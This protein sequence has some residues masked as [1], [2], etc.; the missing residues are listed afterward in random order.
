MDIH[1]LE[2]NSTRLAV[3]AEKVQAVEV[4]WVAHGQE[5]AVLAPFISQRFFRHGFHS[6]SLASW[7]PVSERPPLPVMKE[8]WAHMDALPLFADYPFT[9]SGVSA[10][11]GPDRQILLLGALGLDARLA[12][13]SWGLSGE[14]LDSPLERAP[15]E[16]FIAL[17]PEADVFERYARLLGERL[18]RRAR[19][20]APRVWC[21]WYSLFRDIDEQTLAGILSGV[22]GMR[23]DVFQVDDGW[24]QTLGDWEANDRFPAGMDALAQKIA[25]AG[26]LPGLWLAPF[27]VQPTSSVFLQH[28]DWLLQDEHGKP[29]PAGHNWGDFFYALDTTHP[30]VQEWL[31]NLIERVRGWGYHYLKLDFLYGAA[32][33][34]VRHASLPAEAAYRQAMELVRRTAGE[35]YI[36]VCGSPIIASLGIADGMRIGPDVAPFWDNADRTQNLHDPTGPGTLNALRTSLHRLWLQPLLHVD[37]D[38]TFF[39]T[40]YNLLRSEEKEALRKLAQIT[41]FRATSD[42]VQWLNSEER[43]ALEEFLASQPEIEQLGRYRFRVGQSEIDYGPLIQA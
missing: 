33:P 38:V 20:A 36:L 29:V 22:K 2:T 31:V 35:D 13:R 24:Q 15:H 6:W 14:F 18:G 21:S 1:L 12:A 16:W 17:G 30:E 5:V 40:R 26:F 41:G 19:Q 8:M 37:P 23:F 32:L 9:S 7:L 10:L 42:P 11:E 39:R 28:P 34:A 43:L 25:E 4:G 3:K 27:I